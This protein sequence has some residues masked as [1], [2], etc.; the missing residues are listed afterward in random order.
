MAK[1]RRY[2][3]TAKLIRRLND[4]TFIY[5]RARTLNGYAENQVSCCSRIT[6][7]IIHKRQ[8][9]GGG[10]AHSN[11]IRGR[12]IPG[13]MEER[14]NRRWRYPITAQRARRHSG[15]RDSAVSCRH[16]WNGR[17][18]SR[19]KRHCRCVRSVDVE[20]QRLPMTRDRDVT[21]LW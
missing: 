21:C 9:G 3:P 14:W 4:N 12:V 11:D 20:N 7:Y 10:N 15:L 2:I 13:R 5:G 8:G 16:G 1:P 6:V 17:V 18:R 19:D